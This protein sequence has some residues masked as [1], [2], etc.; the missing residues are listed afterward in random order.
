MLLVSTQSVASVRLLYRNECSSLQHTFRTKADR[1]RGKWQSE[2]WCDL[3]DL[4]FETV[5]K[6]TLPQESV[7]RWL[8]SEIPG[9]MCL[10]TAKAILTCVSPTW[11]HMKVGEFNKSYATFI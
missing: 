5:K 1:I 10:R 9:F 11:Q 6:I 3:A 4:V 7:K 8:H 2:V